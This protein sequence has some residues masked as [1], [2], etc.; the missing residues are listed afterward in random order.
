[1]RLTQLTLPMFRLLNFC[2]ALALSVSLQAADDVPKTP[3]QLEY[4]KLQEQRAQF[5]HA[6][7]ALQQGR[8]THYRE[9]LRP[10]LSNYP[11]LPYLDYLELRSQLKKRPYAQVD[12][13]LARYESTALGNDLLEDWLNTL[14]QQ[15]R[16]HEFQSY[17]QTHINSVKLQCKYLYARLK[18]GEDEAFDEITAL[19]NVGKSQPKAC[20]PIFKQWQDKGHLSA[21]LAWERHAKAIKKRKRSL[22]RYLDRYLSEEQKKVA[23]LYRE[24]DRYPNRIRHS[25]RFQSQSPEMKEVIL[26][27]IKRLARS[28]PDQAL[29]AWELYD[30]QQLFSDEDRA[31][32]IEN[33]IVKLAQKSHL[34]KVDKLLQQTGQ[35]RSTRLLELMLRE[36]LGA[37]Q[38]AQAYH[39]LQMLPT[40]LQQED[41]WKYWRARSIEALGINDPVFL[42][43]REIY[44]T[45]SLKRSFYGFLAADRVGHPYSLINQPINP[46][47]A[48]VALIQ[49]LPGIQR[50]KEFFALN[51]INEARSEWYYSTRHL[52]E[53]GIKATA[54]LAEDWGWYRKSIQAMIDI[55]H[56]DDLD[57]RFPLAYPDAVSG[58]AAATD[59]D[60]QLLFAIARQESAFS[61]DAKSPAGALGLMQLMPSTAKY[62]AKRSGLNYRTRDL[63]KPEANITLGSRYL[64]SLLSQFEGN[65]ILAAAAYNAGPT[66]VRQWLR[67]SEGK[68]P[69]D[70]WI[71][72]IPFKETRGYVQNVLAFSV[73]YGYKLGQQPAMV[74]PVEAGRAL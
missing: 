23:T 51:Y 67:A 17:Y 12:D 54:K 62:T 28:K 16:W 72:T 1:M 39:W 35:T 71:E 49:N 4:A 14:A 18:H 45:L 65:R 50:A 48:Q 56:W 42:S 26:H 40:E 13:Y 24:V 7:L 34:D 20:D 27:G 43:A 37:Q 5:K 55:K 6:Q 57:M 3:L 36:S 70:V 38:W 21:D 44:S 11:L 59:I 29:K 41:R 33:L 53:A 60:P 47:P 30:A 19:W 52:D 69:F 64:N 63:L 9:T 74:K 61:P 73:I 10:K 32:A 58:A 31:A 25:K 66:R 2:V 46:A 15:K 22:A 68:K 8:R